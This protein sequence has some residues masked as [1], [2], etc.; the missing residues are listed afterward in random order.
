M[1]P[2]E[3][4]QITESSPVEEQ[5]RQIK[6]FLYRQA[7][8][9]N[10]NL[11]SSDI[12]SIWKQTAEALS[13]SS[14]DEVEEMRRDEFKALRSLII[15][16]AT[17]IIK[18]E[19]TF[20]ANLSGNYTAESD[21][22]TFS[23]E[24]HIYINGNPYT[25][26]QVY[27]Y[28]AQIVAKTSGLAE[29]VAGMAGDVADVVTYKTDMEGFIRTGV[30]ERETS[31]PVF[32]MEIGY[33]KNK[34]IVNGTEYTN[35]NPAKIRI[36]PDRIGL[37]QNNFEA[38][39]IQNKAIYFPAAHIT[40]G[41]I[42]L[43]TN[44]EFTVDQFGNLVANSA[45]I[46]G[47]VRA[48]S[49]II[50]GFEIRGSSLS[51]GEFWPCSLSSIL[52]PESG[53]SKYAVFMRGFYN[54]NGV[55]YGAIDN[56]HVVFGLKEMNKNKSDWEKDAEYLFYVNGKGNIHGNVIEANEFTMDQ[57]KFT[58]NNINLGFMS[59]RDSEGTITNAGYS[60]PIGLYT[61]DEI[62]IGAF[63]SKAKNIYLLASDTV[64]IGQH[65]SES[66]V[67]NSSD[68]PSTTNVKIQAK[69]LFEVGTSNYKVESANIYA[70]TTRFEGLVIPNKDDSYNLGSTIRYW[71]NVYATTVNANYISGYVT[72]GEDVS[73]N[74]IGIKVGNDGQLTLCGL[75]GDKEYKQYTLQTIV[76]YMRTSRSMIEAAESTANTA[77]STANTAESTANTAKST[78]DTNASNIIALDGN[79]NQL[80]TQCNGHGTRI[81]T[82]EGIIS[83]LKTA[84]NGHGTKISKCESDIFNLQTAD[85][86]IHQ[87]LAVIENKL[88]I[89]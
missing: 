22:G 85:N 77:K 54:E 64:R 59:T 12:V 6:S 40:G 57:I 3:L 58:S 67:E 75:V 24:G 18:N 70:S 23:E 36:T 4:P 78:A 43:G 80:K 31:T 73:D 55:N 2:Y 68:A 30:L 65:S 63:K 7:E 25:I 17:S 56:T 13:V 76:Q 42:E 87:R 38:A 84:V 60:K 89:S 44:K 62:K 33:N 28:Q 79:L 51:D 37:W 14:N 50:G 48:K 52:T 39:Y 8:N 47:T 71:K 26:G 21:Y 10:Y 15:K 49:G 1:R 88:G 61:S 11:K 19:D 32:G 5:L 45:V 35:N 29:D 53:T 86:L 81:A 46:E 9:L 34:Y 16:S 27:K 82:N 69:T 74:F 72:I 20:S 83:S 66:A 41:S